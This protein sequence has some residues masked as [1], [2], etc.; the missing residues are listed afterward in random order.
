MVFL[1][2]Y[3]EGETKGLISCHL[4]YDG[5]PIFCSQLNED[6]LGKETGT[7]IRDAGSGYIGK[8]RSK[9]NTPRLYV[10]PYVVP[11]VLGAD[12]VR[13]V[14]GTVV[15]LVPMSV[16]QGRVVVMEAPPDELVDA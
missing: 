2:S 14:P 5:Q 16:V 15:T 8:G 1:L 10:E 7:S 3:C 6:S 11:L 13:L 12:V 4:G 9:V